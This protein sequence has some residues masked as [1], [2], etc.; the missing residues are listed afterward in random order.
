MLYHVALWSSS[1]RWVAKRSIVYLCIELHCVG[2]RCDPPRGVETGSTALYTCVM[3]CVALFLLN[4]SLHSQILPT[5]LFESSKRLVRRVLHPVFTSG[6]HLI[7]SGNWFYIR[8]LHPDLI[9]SNSESWIYIR[10]LHLE[11]ISSHPETWI[12]IRY[13]HPDLI[14][15]RILD[16]HPVFTSGSHLISSR[17][18]FY[19][20]HLHLVLISSRILDLHPVF[21]SGSHLISSR[22]LV[23]HL[24]FTI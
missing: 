21:T 1:R 5:S 2:L 23:L 10:Y 8:Y 24:V 17:N 16:L 15:S 4:N 3:C 19:I 9:S 13:L 22:I 14:S 11:L 7:S 12:Y 6:S 18:W 20:R